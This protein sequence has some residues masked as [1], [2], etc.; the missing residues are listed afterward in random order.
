[1]HLALVALVAA[2]ASVGPASRSHAPSQL[3][4]TLKAY[5][6]AANRHDWQAVRALMAEDAVIEL[7]EGLSLVGAE[8]ARALHDWER[9]MG[10][11]THYTKCTVSG[12]AVTCRATEENDFLR[13]AGLGPI[14]YSSSTITFEK[15]RVSRMRATLSDRSAEAVS[16][17]MQPFLEWASTVEPKGVETFLKPD[18]SFAFGFEGALTFKRLVRLYG[19]TRGA[20]VRAL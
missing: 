5:E 6:E 9:A 20:R 8:H 3:L 17:Y 4:A 14:E 16:R 7:G 12:D 19:L 11:E 1:M 2:L 18:G 10:T 15:G 13:L